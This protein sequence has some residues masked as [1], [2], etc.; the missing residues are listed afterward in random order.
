[1]QSKPKLGSK[2]GYEEA[3]RVNQHL[4]GQLKELANCLD[5]AIDKT[6]FKKPTLAE[7]RSGV[8]KSPET[9]TKLKEKELSNAYAQLEIYKKEN[10]KL[11]HKLTESQN[12]KDSVVVLAAKLKEI[13]GR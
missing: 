8:S 13:E 9:L 7:T 12:T 1:M 2:Q 10:E 4:R 3:I 5:N 11:K 6:H